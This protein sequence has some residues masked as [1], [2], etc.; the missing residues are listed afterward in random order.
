MGEEL[1]PEQSATLV[2]ALDHEANPPNS[3]ASKQPTITLEGP[4]IDT[5]ADRQISSLGLSSV[6]WNW[7]RQQQS[8]YPLGIDLVFVYDAKVLALPRS[9]RLYFSQQPERASLGQI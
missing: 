9:T 7:R 4:G 2:I 5:A 8:L 1:A 6:F 3:A